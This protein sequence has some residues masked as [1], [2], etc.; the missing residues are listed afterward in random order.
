[1]S[2]GTIDWPLALSQCKNKTPIL[3]LYTHECEVVERMFNSLATKRGVTT[4]IVNITA[5]DDEQKIRGILQKSVSSVSNAVCFF[6]SFSIYLYGE[7]NSCQRLEVHAINLSVAR[8]FGLN[9]SKSTLP[10]YILLKAFDCATQFYCK[11]CN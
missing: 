7:N 1:M 2:D 8:C 10:L 6:G 5:A 3:L 4:H 9:R 11:R